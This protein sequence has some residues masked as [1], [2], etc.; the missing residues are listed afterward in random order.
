MKNKHLCRCNLGFGRTIQ[1][2][3]IDLVAGSELADA[4]DRLSVVERKRIT[5]AK[6]GLG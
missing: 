6:D 2:D 5:F 4:V 3:K 1:K